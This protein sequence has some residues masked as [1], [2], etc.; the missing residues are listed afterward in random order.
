MLRAGLAALLNQDTGQQGQASSQKL[1]CRATAVQPD[2]DICIV[3]CQLP[4]RAFSPYQT[5]V[6]RGPSHM[7]LLMS[8]PPDVLSLFRHVGWLCKVNSKIG[9][10]AAFSQKCYEHPESLSRLA[11]FPSLQSLWT[12]SQDGAH[13]L[14][15]CIAFD[16]DFIQSFFGKNTQLCSRHQSGTATSRLFQRQAGFG[17][18][19]LC[20][21]SLLPGS[22]RRM[23]FKLGSSL[24]KSSESCRKHDFG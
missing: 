22:A 18:S 15:L 5:F 8:A 10:S 20:S 12:L 1:K 11:R 16:L 3:L 6:L 4:H 23:G 13:Y 14:L 24:R 17:S 9:T 7:C 19:R 2:M 21:S